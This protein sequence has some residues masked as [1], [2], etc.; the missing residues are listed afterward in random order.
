MAMRPE[1][2]NEFGGSTPGDR[3]YGTPGVD[4]MPMQRRQPDRYDATGPLPPHAP[5]PPPYP[6][7]WDAR[8][9]SDTERTIELREE[10][11][12]AHKELHE[13]GEVEIR[14]VVEETPGR[15]E[16]DAFS[17]EVHVEH[18]PVG[19]TVSERKEP[20]Q[21]GD[22]M[23][24]PVYEEQLV[25]TK[26]LVLREELHI[27]RVRTTERQLYEDTL[28]RERLVVDD[29][30]NTG[31]V[32]ERYPNEG[33]GADDPEWRA[34]KRIPPPLDHEPD[35]GGLLGIVKKALH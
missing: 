23:V 35:E 2:P 27:R 19:Q 8:A 5:A 3:M 24:V 7:D 11:L 29:P 6:A 16:V 31:L 9:G 34:S 10:Q 32:H 12:I 22:V 13:L 26:R 21:E 18:V 30:A 33:G 14:K 15:L 20:W 28:R 1:Y 17:E 4:D 25:V